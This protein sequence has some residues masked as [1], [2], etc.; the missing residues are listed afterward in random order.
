MADPCFD[1]Y[2][3]F[4]MVVLL[5]M[6]TA[7]ARLFS[8]S[9]I[10]THPRPDIVSHLAETFDTCM[11]ELISLMEAN[12]YDSDDLWSPLAFTRAGQGAFVDPEVRRYGRQQLQRI[13]AGFIM[14]AIYPM[15]EPDVH[16]WLAVEAEDEEVIQLAQQNCEYSECCASASTHRFFAWMR[17]A[18]L[19]ELQTAKQSCTPSVL[20]T[21]RDHGGN[22]RSMRGKQSKARVWRRQV[23]TYICRLSKARWMR[24]TTQ[25]RFALRRRAGLSWSQFKARMDLASGNRSS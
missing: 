18:L 17:T 13:C 8:C 20:M 14:R 19:E 12:V 10:E 23:S 1:F 5:P 21:E 16:C 6:H 22:Q 3:A 25:R 4:S 9:K 2:V 24:G 11:T 15:S 7:M